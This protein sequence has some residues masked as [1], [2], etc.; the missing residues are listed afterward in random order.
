MLY[1]KQFS[2]EEAGNLMPVHHNLYIDQ[3]KSQV[4]IVVINVRKALGKQRIERSRQGS[5]DVD[6]CRG[7]GD[8][9]S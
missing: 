9:G 7:G 1:L 2:L 3:V 8:G 5:R 4:G 6:L